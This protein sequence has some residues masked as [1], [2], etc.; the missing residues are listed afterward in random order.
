MSELD[1]REIP[2]NERHDRIRDAFDALAL[3]IVAAV[4]LPD[5][6]L[7]ALVYSNP[8]SAFRVLALSGL[9]TTAGGGFT[10]VLAGTGSRPPRCL[11]RSS[12]GVSS[13]SRPR[14]C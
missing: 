13:P 9:E 12:R 10:A 6:A 7:S 3:G 11:S 4:D 8:V 1:V 14:A 5:A 2:P